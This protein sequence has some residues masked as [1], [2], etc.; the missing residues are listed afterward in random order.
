MFSNLTK[1]LITTVCHKLKGNMYGKCGLMSR[2]LALTL[3]Q[4][5]E[6]NLT[7]LIFNPQLHITLNYLLISM[8]LYNIPK[9]KC[10]SNNT[11]IHCQ[12]KF[13]QIW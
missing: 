6:R 13:Q 8:T 11:F 1:E 2:K 5:K 9:V 12:S 4:K 10:I 3:Q 7:V